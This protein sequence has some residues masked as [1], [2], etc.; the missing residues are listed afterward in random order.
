MG[1][2]SCLVC[3]PCLLSSL[4]CSVFS[5]DFL[6]CFCILFL[7]I[8]CFF[9]CSCFWFLFQKCIKKLRNMKSKHKKLEKDFQHLDTLLKQ[10]PK[11]AAEKKAAYRQKQ[12]AETTEKVR[13]A[14]RARMAAHRAELDDQARKA[15]LR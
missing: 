13:A 7:S 4:S 11:T 6:S 14:N 5:P 9:F 1:C 15:A 2:L 3:S 10:K 8:S 12:T